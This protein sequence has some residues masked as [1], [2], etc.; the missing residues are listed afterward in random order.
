MEFS[1][2][3]PNDSKGSRP[4]GGKD[5][6]SA[7]KQPGWARGLRDLYDAVVDEPL[8]DSFEDLLKKLDQAKDD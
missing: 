8:P 5:G 3:R 2:A 4:P 1:L 6:M 7:D